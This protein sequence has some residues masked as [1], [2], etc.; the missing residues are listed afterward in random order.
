MVRLIHNT[1]TNK[2]FTFPI[3]T[4]IPIGTNSCN[5]VQLYKSQTNMKLKLI[6]YGIY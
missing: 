5:I 3:Q 6:N 2:G 1:L 4:N